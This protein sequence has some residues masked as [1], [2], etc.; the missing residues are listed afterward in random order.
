M[1]LPQGLPLDRLRT[2]FV[3]RQGERSLGGANQAIFGSYG[4]PASFNGE[5]APDAYD[6]NVW[7]YSAVSKV[8]NELAR[9]QFELRTKGDDPEPVASHQGLETL[10]LPQ[11]IKSG[12]S[13]LTSSA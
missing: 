1:P 5:A 4:V 3:G 8:A 2:A 10:N 7:L 13:M 9:T 12:Q 11:P 6:D